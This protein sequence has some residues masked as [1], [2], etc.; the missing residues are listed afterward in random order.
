MTKTSTKLKFRSS[1]VADREGTL[2]FQIIYDRVVRQL[3]TGYKI[4]D[5]EWNSEKSIIV[6][7]S[8][9][10]RNQVLTSI[11]DNIR[12]DI[13]RLNRII[14]DFE[15]RSY[16]YTP[17]EVIAEFQRISQEHT[18]F[19]FMQREI[20]QLLQRGK[21][22]TSETYQTTLN[23][24]RDYRNGEDIMLDAITSDEMQ[25][26][27]GSMTARG[28]C[29][30]T[31]SFYMRILRAVYNKHVYTGISKTVKRAISLN[32]IKRVKSLELPAN[33]SLSLA[34]D[35]FLFSFYTRGMTFV[36]MANLRRK[37]VECGCITYR[38]QKTGQL[39]NIKI[40]KCTQ[41]IINRYHNPDSDY[42]FPIIK[43][44]GKE[45][46]EYKNALKLIN[47]RLKEIG[48]MIGTPIKLTTYV[49][50]HSWGSAA[51]TSNIP[52]S[53][54]CE[55][56]GHDNETTTQIYLASLDTSIIDQANAKILSKL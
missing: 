45:Y 52:I 25:L 49:G 28:L 18:L 21:I 44:A 46:R 13:E 36:D 42:V 53:V 41:E 33:T 51:K 47:V 1:S 54:I 12:W 19:N 32:D 5:N 43:T 3:T 4:F 16:A 50:R 27:E 30:N 31:T 9:A 8:D 23:S 38:R 29:P 15:K 22:R 11:S 37:D 17:D 7:S 48:R 24:Y 20:T 2:Y 55:S 10:T 40:E 35:L 14:N 56:M 39:L 6:Y 26:Y 34:R